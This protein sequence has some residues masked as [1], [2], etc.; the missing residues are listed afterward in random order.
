MPIDISAASLEEI[1]DDVESWAD[2][3]SDATDK[4]SRHNVYDAS[5]DVVDDVVSNPVLERAQSDAEPHIGTERIDKIDAVSG[6]WVTNSRYE[7]G[8]STENQVVLAHERGTGVYASSGPYRITPSAG[9][10]ALAF[11]TGSGRVVVD[12]VVHPGVRGKNFMRKAV[13]SHTRDV[14]QRAGS[15]ALDAVI[16]SME[17]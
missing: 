3:L 1:A 12:Y 2:G 5:A 10:D 13:R 9:R 11:D 8:L 6:Q 4:S 17:D 15:E 14:A 16:R 7:S